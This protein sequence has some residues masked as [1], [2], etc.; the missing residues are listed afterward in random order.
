[1][2]QL[3]NHL[4]IISLIILFSTF[5]VQAHVPQFAQDN[6]RLEAAKTIEAPLKTWVIYS[7]LEGKD[8]P[9][10]YIFKIEKGQKL[11][12]QIIT[13]SPAFTPMLTIMG[14]GI[15][16]RDNPPEFIETPNEGGIKVV[17]GKN[18]GKATYEAHAPSSYFE[19]IR[20]E[21]V[22]KEGGTY[23]L[24]VYD[25]K[26]GGRY[27]LSIGNR[28]SFELSEWLLIPVNVVRLHL[29]EGQSLLFIMAPLIISVVIGLWFLL[30]RGDYDTAAPMTTFILMGSFSAFLY[31]GSSA[32]TL[33]QMMIAIYAA[34]IANE[35]VITIFK[36]IIPLITGLALLHTSGADSGE[37]IS[38]ERRLR[39][40]VLGL[41]GMFVWAGLLL[42]PILA[43]LAAVSP[44]YK[45]R[46]KR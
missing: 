44:S 35:V 7:E 27:G 14:P 15:V 31:I 25:L 34:G 30:R 22:I 37:K 39:M 20:V 4:L 38:F 46:L 6:R 13:K 17:S 23:Y 5:L 21:E 29:W 8:V 26:G 3:K 41:V 2:N 16:S 28:E 1:M 42:G 18:P 12:M 43:I 33:I 32:M 36:A 9:N 45:I 11:K 24:A 40:L 10:Y 19:V